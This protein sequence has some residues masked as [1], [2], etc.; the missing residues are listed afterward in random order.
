[1][2]GDPTPARVLP[3]RCPGALRAHQAADGLLA[4]V[5]LPGGFLSAE[6]LLTLV[7]VAAAGGDPRLELT[8][9]AN[10]QVRALAEHEV[11]LS[12]ARLADAGLLPSVTHERVRNIM[13]SPLAG[14]DSPTDLA[15]VVAELDTELCARPGLA[16]LPGRFL[17]G[18]DDG[19]GDIAS[20]H[21]D[22]T[23]V[24]TARTASVCGFSVPRAAV[25]PTALAFAESFLAERAVQN[26]AAWRVAELT[27]GISVVA[28]RALAP[29]GFEVP[30]GRD[31]LPPRLRPA[32]LVE[33]I[34]GGTALVALAPLGRL[35]SA[36][37]TL[38]ARHAGPRGLRVTPWR[39]IV[40]PDLPDP[41][42]FAAAAADLGLGVD[43]T[44]P[45][46]WL[47]ACTGTPGCTS[48]LADVQTDAAA[49][50]GRW[51]GRHAHFSGCR[52]RCGRP[53]DTRIDVIATDEGYV[54]SD[55]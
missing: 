16:D 4:R 30:A 45:W 53:A 18:V 50:A 43:D 33:Q 17:F 55:D 3:D 42:E 14:L 37:A 6:Q 21:P 8:T 5:R 34:D 28:R 12:A 15:A 29:G 7:A 46:Y 9:R 41:E 2:T 38:L 25:V 35:S 47:S 48:A 39:G 49:A 13:A 19:R 54:F 22:I 26:S 31:V 32:G 44:S 27:G 36:Q 24:L 51:P 10:V 52:R 23:L 40:L 1:M 20:L 11:A